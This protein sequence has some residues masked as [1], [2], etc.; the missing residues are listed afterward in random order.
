MQ[1]SVLKA[2]RFVAQSSFCVTSAGGHSCLFGCVMIGNS[3][4]SNLSDKKIQILTPIE[5]GT[6]GR[7]Q[8]K[9]KGK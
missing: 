4:V 7:L 3:V 6:D 2:R 8:R 5:H 9:I 1:S